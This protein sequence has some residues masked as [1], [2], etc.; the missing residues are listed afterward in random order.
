VFVRNRSE[1]VQAGVRTERRCTGYTTE[2]RV[3]RPATT[4]VVAERV[5]IPARR[6]TVAVGAPVHEVK[7]LPGT[8]EVL[9]QADFDRL[10]A[11]ANGR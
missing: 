1:V 3:I 6:V 9:A 11:Q 7:P 8:T 10:V 2:E 4:Q 5:V